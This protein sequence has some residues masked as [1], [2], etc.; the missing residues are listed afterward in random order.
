MEKVKVNFLLSKEIVEK[1]DRVYAKLMLSGKKIPKSHIVEE[2]LREKLER[3][4]R[5]LKKE[6]K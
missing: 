3:I 6:E 2:A 1:L 5:E 4:E